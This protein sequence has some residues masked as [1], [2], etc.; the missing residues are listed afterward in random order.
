MTQRQLWSDNTVL[1]AWLRSK[2]ILLKINETVFV[3]GG[4]SPQVLAQQPSIE[5]IDKLAAESFVT[6]NTV[7]KN[8]EQSIL[9]SSQGLLFYRGLAKDMSHYGL[10]NKA[11]AQHIEQVLSFYEA[12]KIA[13][14]HT[15]SQNI[16]FDYQEKVI[17]VDVDH[18]GGNSEALLIDNNNYYRVNNRGEAI[19][20]QPLPILGSG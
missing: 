14:G 4:V 1:G 12:E 5:L 20:L 13:I 19:P 9:H 8:S 16:G 7:V 11:S 6:S 15:L 18:A 10:G 17:R 2:P 3:H